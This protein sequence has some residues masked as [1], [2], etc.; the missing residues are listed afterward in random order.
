MAAGGH[1][2]LPVSQVTVLTVVT[3]GP[4]AL[5]ATFPGHVLEVRG[6]APSPPAPPMN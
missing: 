6:D 5:T 3:S 1:Q 2:L 4:L